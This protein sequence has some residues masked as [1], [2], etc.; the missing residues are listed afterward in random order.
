MRQ[1]IL[2]PAATKAFTLVEILVALTI[3]SVLTAVALP[4]VKEALRQNV[5]GRSATLVKGAFI[6]ARAQALRTGR[7]FGLVIERQRRSVGSGTPNQLNFTAAN[8][9][10]R[11]YYVQTP[12][13]YRGDIDSAYA[14]PFNDVAASN[15]PKFFIPETSAAL[16]AAAARQRKAALRIINT[17][18][19]MSVGDSG[20]VFTLTGL[21]YV[22]SLSGRVTGA[23]ASWAGV[24]GTIVSFNHLTVEPTHRVGGNHVN[25]QP[26]PF[27]ILSLPTRAPLTPVNLPGKTVVDLS[28][29]GPS[30]SPVGFGTQAIVG[31]GSVPAG[32]EFSDVIVMFSADGRLDSVYV[33]Q[34]DA[35]SPTGYRLTRLV[36]GATISFAIGYV[37]GIVDN[38]DDMARYPQ[39]VPNTVF[40]SGANVPPLA[41]P[42][43]PEPL[44][45]LGQVPNFANSECAWV[46]IRPL[47]GAIQLGSVAGQPELSALVNSYGF[48]P[49]ANPPSRAIVNARLL[50]SR[51]LLTAGATK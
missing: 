12:I 30:N 18:T 37:D 23:S 10:T 36:F 51:R 31:I 3:A 9:A 15:A 42:A 4:T 11:L 5:T 43:P 32:Y 46:A 16:V 13:A 7:P 29:S 17:G 6:N 41:V 35:T 22:S 40:P 28:I 21:E 48:G 39:H 38:I 45:L 14:Y 20:R 8:Y 34:P 24:P 33:D 25:H 27:E 2:S 49:P 47:S 26:Y 44:N 50:Q 1:A 19:Q